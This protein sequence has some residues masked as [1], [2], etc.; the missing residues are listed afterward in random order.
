MSAQTAPRPP[1]GL[2]QYLA[3]AM[4][5]EAG[6]TAFSEPGTAW[7]HARSAWL[8]HADA[9]VRAL[10]RWEEA[11]TLIRLCTIPGCLRQLDIAQPEP[12]WQQ[13]RTVGCMCPD[14]NQ[15]LWAEPAGPHIPCW[16][17]VDTTE[18]AVLRCSCGWCAGETRFRGHGTALWQ[19]HVLEVLD[20]KET[21]A[22]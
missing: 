8:A 22:T 3:E 14:H 1:E 20:T 19:A 10:H 2:R 18:E 5:K 6:S 9:A 16:T 12:G 15:I 13:S 21:A 4:A 7:D 17:Y 11:G